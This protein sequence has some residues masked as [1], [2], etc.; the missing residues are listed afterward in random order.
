MQLNKQ[1]LPTCSE[2]KGK[3]SK[4]LL[5]VLDE[6]SKV[7]IFVQSILCLKLV[8]NFTVQVA[9]GTIIEYLAT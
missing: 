7:C 2:N 8:E 9:L 6:S 5:L 1:A 3:F 4:L